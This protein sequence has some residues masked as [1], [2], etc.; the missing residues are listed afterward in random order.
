M[1]EANVFDMVHDSG[2][3][4]CLASKKTLYI[5]ENFERSTAYL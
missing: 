5:A 2:S 1:L 4:S 3:A